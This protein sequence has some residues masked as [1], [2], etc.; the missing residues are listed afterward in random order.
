MKPG[1]SCKFSYATVQQADSLHPLI[2]LA[3]QTRTV[4]ISCI[5]TSNKIRIFDPFFLIPQALQVSD[6][7]YRALLCYNLSSL[8]CSQE[9][10]VWTVQKSLLIWRIRLLA[11]EK[12]KLTEQPLLS[13]LIS[14]IMNVRDT[15][16]ALEWSRALA[17]FMVRPASCILK[18]AKSI[19][20]AIFT[21]I[22]KPA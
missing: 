9:Y 10:R 7:A 20:N 16:E 14:L 18:S 4:S 17:I 11:V 19:F 6:E 12:R 5:K 22:K 3:R 13:P 21:D 2:C 15:P 8:V 1:R